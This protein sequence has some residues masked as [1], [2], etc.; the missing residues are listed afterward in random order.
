VLDNSTVQELKKNLAK[1]QGDYQEKL[2][3][4][5]PGYPIMTQ[6]E[7]QIN[8]LQGQ[9]S[10]ETSSI[11][12]TI[13][14]SLKADYQAAKQRETQLRA[15]LTKQ[16]D[17]LL[18]LRDKSIGYNTLQREVETNRNL[19][20]GLLQRIK[21]VGVAAGVGTNNISVVDP[22]II[23]YAKHKPNTTLNLA[24]GMVLGLFL[25]TV[26]AFLLEF[27]DDRVKTP[28]DL[29]RLL[30]LPMLGLIPN[31]KIKDERELATLT[32][33]QPQSAV[34][35][36]FRSLRTNL[37]FATHEGAPKVLHITSALPAE[38]KS[39]TAINLAIIFAQSG[40]KVLLVDADLRKPALHKRLKLDNS[41]GLSNYL[42]SQADLHTLIQ[43]SSITGIYVLTSGPLPPNP[44]ELLSS[45]RLLEL[46]QRVPIE[47]DMIILDS[48][49]VM[50]LADALVLSNRATATVLVAAAN[51]SKKR[52][53]HDA[54]ERLLRARANLIGVVFTKVK[55]GKSYGYHYDYEYYY[56]YGTNDKHKKKLAKA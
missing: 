19:Y 52:P 33:T 37:L 41:Q 49:P 8:E 5:K 40:K 21:E 36:A 22:A 20:E 53:L 44:A 11:T 48:P 30:K 18:N 29:E 32:Q 31:A 24:L 43:T 3:I 23:P 1:L 51:Q 42:T 47:F 56:T 4:Y 45:E 10:Q 27:L 6:L 39:S 7:S 12:G 2:Q 38:G 25:G 28:Q 34:A 13:T 50:G 26:V 54:H 46:A 14:D 9:I 16:K 17:D 35:E 15:D 55:S